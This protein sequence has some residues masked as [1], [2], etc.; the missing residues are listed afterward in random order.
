MTTKTK[1]YHSRLPGSSFWDKKGTQHIFIGGKITT[2]DEDLQQELDA[3]LAQGANPLMYQPDEVLGIPAVQD[4]IAQVQEQ[5]KSNAATSTA[6]DKK[7][8]GQ[9]VTPAAASL[10]PVSTA[11]GQNATASNSGSK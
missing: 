10:N 1:T 9:L 4:E 2:D 6:L 11:G 8:D 3:I 7:T 5:V